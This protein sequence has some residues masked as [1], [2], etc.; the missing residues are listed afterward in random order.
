MRFNANMQA[1]KLRHRVAIQAATDT[2]TSD[3]SITRTWA[4]ADTVW[5][6]VEPLTGRELTEAMKVAGMATL[7]VTI[8]YYSG[9]TTAH[10]LLFGTRVLEIVNVGNTDER[11]RT[12]AVLCTETD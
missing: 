4:T 9:L 8:R 1:G 7:R 10:R 2:R 6:S 5:A 11:N 3:G 12:L